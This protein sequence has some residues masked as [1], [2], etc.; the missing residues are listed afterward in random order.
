[1]GN[2][3]S[4]KFFVGIKNDTPSIEINLAI[5]SLKLH[6]P[7]PFVLINFI[8][9]NPLLGIYPKV[10]LAKLQ[11]ARCKK[12]FTIVSVIAKGWKQPELSFSRKQVE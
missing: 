8:L 7:L 2:K 4:H 12:F 1:M 11:K 6:M 5:Q 10:V 9:A 3:Y